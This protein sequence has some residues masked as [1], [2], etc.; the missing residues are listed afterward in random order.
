VR[1]YDVLVYRGTDPNLAI[2]MLTFRK[3]HVPDVIAALANVA[4]LRQTNEAVREITIDELLIGHELADDLHTAKG[5]LLVSRGQVITER[6][7][8]RVRN[9][10]ASTGLQGRILVADEIHVDV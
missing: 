2:G 10:Q 5:L 3:V 7:L 9:F 8:V 6:L 4:D 1:E